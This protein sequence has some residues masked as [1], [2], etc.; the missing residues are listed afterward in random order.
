MISDVNDDLEQA[1]SVCGGS[2]VDDDMSSAYDEGTTSYGEDDDDPTSM[3]DATNVGNF[4]KGAAQ[5]RRQLAAKEV[6]TVRRIK[7]FVICFLFTITI[8]VAFGAYLATWNSEGGEFVSQFNE[9]ATK[10]VHTMGRNLILTLQA[11]DAFTVSITS[12]AMA[13][14]QSW[15]CV[16]VPD[17]AVRAEKIRSLANSVYVNTYIWVEPDERS[18]WENFTA[19]TGPA[20]VDESVEAIAEFDGME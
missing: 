15:P 13:T 7:Y 10:I 2:T 1:K 14:N 20:W 12:M 18:K 11:A 8:A 9:D 5:P 17:F 4:N 3:G 6:Q 19:L 16:V